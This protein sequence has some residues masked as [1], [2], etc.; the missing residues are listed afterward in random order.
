MSLLKM[1]KTPEL[2]KVNSY[3]SIKIGEILLDKKGSYCIVINKLDK[4]RLIVVEYSS[5][6]QP[7]GTM[8]YVIAY[9]EERIKEMYRVI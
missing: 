5:Y 1:K 6:Y 9:P 7:K 2:K 3:E 4:R 8:Q